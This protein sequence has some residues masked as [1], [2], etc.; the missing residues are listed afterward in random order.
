MEGVVNSGEGAEREFWMGRC[1]GIVEVSVEEDVVA[2]LPNDTI[3][4]SKQTIPCSP[5]TTPK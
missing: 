5:S 4:R 2:H 1:S 3:L